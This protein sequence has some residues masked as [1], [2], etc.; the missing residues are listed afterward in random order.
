MKTQINPS[1]K[2]AGSVLMTSLMTGFTIGLTLASYLIMVQQQNT[3]V[4]RSQVWNSGISVT[5][6]GVEEGLAHLN[7]AEGLTGALASNG[8]TNASGGVYQLSRTISG[9]YYNVKIETLG[10]YPIITSDGYALYKYAS[11]ATPMFAV[12]DN[13]GTVS[14]TPQYMKR[15]VQVN[16]KFDGLL[17]A[18]MAAKERINL[19][20]NNISS[21]SF[22]SSTETYSTGGLYDVAKR[23]DNGDIV[24][25]SVLTNTFDIGN[26]NIRGTVR[27]GPKGWPAIGPNGSVGNN[28]WVTA[29][30]KG[31]QAGH[32]FDD[33]NVTFPDVVLPSVTFN[34][35]LVVNT[36]IGGV[37]YKYYLTS[38]SWQ[39]NDLDDSV[40]VDG[41]V[42]VYVPSS[43]HVTLSGQEKIY[44]APNAPFAPPTHS[45][46]LYVGDPSASIGGQGVVNATGIARNF[47]YY[48]LPSNTDLSYSGNGAFLGVVYAPSAIFVLGGGGN[49]T[50]DFIGASVSYRVRMNG[51]FNF[52]YDED[53]K[54]QGPG[55][56]Y[57]VTKWQEL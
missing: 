11:A 23:K 40:Y 26:A 57:I 47:I 4:F 54:K 6:A 44:I 49:N 10:T 38:G 29:G 1:A 33:M 24:T 13:S 5:E 53:L 48:G 20:G 9:G 35:P 7:S 52:H 36:N 34:T 17:T 32:F 14:S 19:R 51:H 37:N 8:W 12:I 25:D 39:I 18:A 31:I 50:Y 27:T 41:D 21:D 46:K 56:V 30:T 16:T 22:D 28:A 15:K 45:M 55:R 43:G 42:V 3:S 2:T